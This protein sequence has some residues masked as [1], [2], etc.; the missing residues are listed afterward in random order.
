MLTRAL[1]VLLSVLNLGVAAWWVTRPD[2]VPAPLPELPSGIARLELVVDETAQAPKATQPQAAEPET[3]EAIPAPPQADLATPMQCQSL[4]PYP[5]RQQAVSA[6]RLLQARQ[7]QVHL[8]EI[9]AAGASAYRVML[10]PTGTREQ[11]LL[12]AAKIGEAGFS[13]YLV[14]PNGNDANGIALG[15]YRSRDSA[16]KRQ[17]ALLAA[18]FEAQ[19]QPMGEFK[20][21]DFWLDVRGPANQSAAQWQSWAG[22]AGTDSLDCGLLR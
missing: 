6:Q 21:A 20:P 14:V 13:D 12:V 4:G 8:R 16:L 22:A 5:Q 1:I 15:L 11:A 19:V 18:G 2:P 17:A 9:P 10:P 7:L 3:A